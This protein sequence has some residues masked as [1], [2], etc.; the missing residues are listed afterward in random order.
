MVS[1]Q[2]NVVV[3]RTRTYGTVTIANNESLSTEFVTG[4]RNIVKVQVPTITSATLSFQVQL[5]KGGD[6]Q[7]LYDDAGEVTTGSASTGART[8]IV[9]QL[10]GHYAI[11][12]RTGTAGSPVAQGAERTIVVSATN[13]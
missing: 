6:F 12:V 3:Q 5:Y 10:A 13:P 11:K 1:E 2:P 4:G 8:F 9:P 7:D